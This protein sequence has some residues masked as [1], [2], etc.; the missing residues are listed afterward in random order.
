[1]LLHRIKDEFHCVDCKDHLSLDFVHPTNFEPPGRSKGPPKYHKKKKE[2]MV[3]WCTTDVATPPLH[4][5]LSSFADCST[6]RQAW[7]W[8]VWGDT[9]LAR[10]DGRLL[11][12]WHRK[13]R[14]SR[15][16]SQDPESLANACN[17]ELH[18]SYYSYPA[19]TSSSRAG[20]RST[21]WSS[22][23]PPCHTL[24][25]R[26]IIIDPTWN[27]A[28]ADKQHYCFPRIGLTPLP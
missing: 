28:T 19:L 14:R 25:P 1:M 10:M 11:G 27:V 3:S 16:K 23:K 18:S 2:S 21:R 8:P 20:S 6:S 24:L 17:K 26:S 12:I 5:L 4:Q 13:S 9:T 22:M 7:M 15:V